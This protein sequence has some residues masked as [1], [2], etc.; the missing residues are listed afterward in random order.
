MTSP[1]TKTLLKHVQGPEVRQWFRD[2]WLGREQYPS[3]LMCDLVANPV[4]G[5]KCT[6]SLVEALSSQRCFLAPRLR[7]YGQ[8]AGERKST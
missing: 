4:N 7:A 3:M 5:P 2:A 1:K 8:R 6:F